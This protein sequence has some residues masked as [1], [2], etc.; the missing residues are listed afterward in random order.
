[1]EGG[2]G[3]TLH[4]DGGEVA[5]LEQRGTEEVEMQDLVLAV[6]GPGEFTA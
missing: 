6:C 4:G 1:M 2:G 3:E 5:F